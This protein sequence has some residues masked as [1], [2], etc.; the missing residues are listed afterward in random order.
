S[1]THCSTGTC[2]TSYSD[3]EQGKACTPQGLDCAYPQ[4][5]CNC[6]LSLP[7]GGHNPVWQCTTPTTGCPEPRAPRGSPCTQDGLS[8]NYGGCTGGVAEQC[9]NGVWHQELLPCPG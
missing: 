2:P 7:V 5:Q 6:A 1:S 3:V 9:K 8:C 4:G